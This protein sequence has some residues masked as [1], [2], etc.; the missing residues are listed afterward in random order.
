MSKVELGKNILSLSDLK[1]GLGRLGKCRRSTAL[2]AIIFGA[3]ALTI[4]PN[5]DIRINAFDVVEDTERAWR[6]KRIRP[7]ENT[8]DI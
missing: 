6:S 4:H 3:V 8:K 2:S 7:N 5:A 1:Q